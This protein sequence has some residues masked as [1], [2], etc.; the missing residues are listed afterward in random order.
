MPSPA[1]HLSPVPRAVRDPRAIVSPGLSHGIN[2]RMW[3]ALRAMSPAGM[4]FAPHVRQKRFA[5]MSLPG[6]SGASESR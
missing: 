2:V 1:L 3:Y 6:C 5:P 4:C